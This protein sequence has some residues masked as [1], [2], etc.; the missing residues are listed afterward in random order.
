MGYLHTFLPTEYI[1]KAVKRLSNH[2]KNSFYQRHSYIIFE[3]NSFVSLE[4][5]EKWLDTKV[6]EQFNTFANILSIDELYCPRD[7]I[8]SNNINQDE[9]KEIKCWFCPDD[10]KLGSCEQFLSRPLSGKKQ[11]VE[12]E[13]LY[14]LAK[15]HILKS[16][17]S[18][19]NCRIPNC[20]KRHHTFST[21]RPKELR[22]Q[23][24]T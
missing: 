15:G 17:P 9:S 11:V 22:R 20:N 1:V 24:K 4:Q 14:Y 10:H 13:E 21:N 19:V 23:T 3:R 18:K 8:T 16:C 12:K 7:H 6:K 2:L 5:F